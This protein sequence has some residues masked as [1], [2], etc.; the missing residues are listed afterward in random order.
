MDTFFL[1]CVLLWVPPMDAAQAIKET[2]AEL[3]AQVPDD[4]T[5]LLNRFHKFLGK[6][7]EK[8]GFKI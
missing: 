2:K 7:C 1:V 5:A 8:A 6:S 4:Y 3:K